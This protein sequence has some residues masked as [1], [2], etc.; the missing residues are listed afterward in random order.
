MARA[1]IGEGSFF[2]QHRAYDK[3]TK[4][5]RTLYEFTQ[6]LR[7]RADNASDRAE[8]QRDLERYE[9]ILIQAIEGKDDLIRS[10]VAS[11]KPRIALPHIVPN[12]YDEWVKQPTFRIG[13]A[14]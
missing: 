5:N 9:S 14:E 6:R 7:D 10:Y 11:R 13:G 4:R 2:Y 12:S 8:H 1:I 3:V